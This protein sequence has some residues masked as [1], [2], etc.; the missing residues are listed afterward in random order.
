MTVW[1]THIRLMYTDKRWLQ[2]TFGNNF[3]SVGWQKKFICGNFILQIENYYWKC[4]TYATVNVK[5]TILLQFNVEFFSLSVFN[6]HY[7]NRTS[8]QLVIL[9]TLVLRKGVDKPPKV[10][11]LVLK[12]AQQRGKTAPGISK[13]ILSLHFSEKISNLPPTP[14]VG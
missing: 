9:L 5:L 14:G 2:I 7:I 6:P 3:L 4:K 10:F 8:F 12:N 13:F 11:A 1:K